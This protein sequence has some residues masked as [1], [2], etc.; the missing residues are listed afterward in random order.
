MSWFVISIATY[1]LAALTYVMIANATV[2]S[3][4]PRMLPTIKAKNAIGSTF[5]H[6]DLWLLCC[7][8]TS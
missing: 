7:S 3:L 4:G 1:Q 8:T 6:A 5:S 2:D